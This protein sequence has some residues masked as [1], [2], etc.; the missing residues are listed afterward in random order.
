MGV[1]SGEVPGVRA[2]RG[3]TVRQC[4]K[5]VMTSGRDEGLV[6]TT[7]KDSALPQRKTVLSVNMEMT[8]LECFSGLV[9]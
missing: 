9:I 4:K 7:S 5:S 3:A 8:P 2:G 1:V 6:V